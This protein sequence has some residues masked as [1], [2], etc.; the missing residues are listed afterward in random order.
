MISF[1]VVESESDFEYRFDRSRMVIIV[2][3]SPQGRR[4][5][6]WRSD[7]GCKLVCMCVCILVP[8]FDP[9]L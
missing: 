5:V 7:F 4:S 2:I 6:L 9:T 8:M 3:G 1:L